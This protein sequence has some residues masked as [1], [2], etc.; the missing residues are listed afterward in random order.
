MTTVAPGTIPFGSRTVPT[1]VPVVTWAASVAAPGSTST[2]VRTTINTLRV[3]GR[4]P[5][6]PVAARHAF[7]RMA[8]SYRHGDCH[9]GI[10]DVNRSSLVRSADYLFTGGWEKGRQGAVVGQL[11][12]PAPVARRRRGRT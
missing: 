4:P 1:S 8:A 2:A 7:E 3:I 12:F 6:S 9:Q 10:A 5:A 11:A